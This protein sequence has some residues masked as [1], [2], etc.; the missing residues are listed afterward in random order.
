MNPIT[1]SILLLSIT[2]IITKSI[3]TTMYAEGYYEY[4]QTPIPENR[5]HVK[6]CNNCIE[7]VK[8]LKFT[9]AGYSIYKIIKQFSNY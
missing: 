3:S 5:S 7:Y 1:R 8:L 2:Y 4:E 6:L 9:R